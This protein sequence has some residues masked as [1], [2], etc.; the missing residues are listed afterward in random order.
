VENSDIQVFDVIEWT[1]SI[2]VFRI[3]VSFMVLEIIAKTE[4]LISGST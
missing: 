2:G 3:C 1:L 4:Y